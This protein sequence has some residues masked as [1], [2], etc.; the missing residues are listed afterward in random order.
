M[1]IFIWILFFISSSYVKE[2]ASIL[3]LLN[4]INSGYIKKI[5]NP[6]FNA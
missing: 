5:F 6:I 2:T 3:K 1:Y 4:I